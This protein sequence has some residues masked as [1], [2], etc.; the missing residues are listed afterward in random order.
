MTGEQRPKRLYKDPNDKMI[1]GVA[2]G[3][4]NYFGL[5]PTVVRL[6]WAVFFGI[7]LIPYIILAIVLQDEPQAPPS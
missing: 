2:A 5:D 6:V 3:V 1:S 4:A 7:G